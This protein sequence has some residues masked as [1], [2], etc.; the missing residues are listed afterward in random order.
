M[1]DS[2][3]LFMDKNRDGAIRFD[4][5]LRGC[6]RTPRRDAAALRP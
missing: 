6:D 4:T 5:A 2:F 3:N 1:A